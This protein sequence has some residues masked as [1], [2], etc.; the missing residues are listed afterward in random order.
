MPN[1]NYKKGAEKERRIVNKLKEEGCLAFRSAGSHSPIDVF[2]LNPFTKK[3]L[4]IQSKPSNMSENM[5]TKI[6]K[7]LLKYE[8]MYE[9]KVLVV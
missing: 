2:G 8:G 3:V 6:L 9:V 5:K 1:K 7:D 4:L